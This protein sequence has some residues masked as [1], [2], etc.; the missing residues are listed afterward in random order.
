[1]P[2]S[3]AGKRR[4]KKK[5]PEMLRRYFWEYH[6]WKLS[7]EK[8]RYT[9]TDRIL[10]HGDID[11]I[12]WLRRKLSDEDLR[13]FILRREGRGLSSRQIRFWELIL[14]LPRKRVNTWLSAPALLL[15]ERRTQA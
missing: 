8:D 11:A 6:F 12:R 9:I 3:T 1:M 13:E 4:G 10:T 15:W 14:K 7:W 2:R 5:L